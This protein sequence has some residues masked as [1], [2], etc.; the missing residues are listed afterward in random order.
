[1]SLAQRRK[2]VEREGSSLSMTRQC[3]L[4]GVSRSG[5]YYRS[6]GT[7]D[8]DLVLTQAMERQYLETPLYE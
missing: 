8:E 6:K 7:S 2:R 3:A 1:M 5:L 4:T